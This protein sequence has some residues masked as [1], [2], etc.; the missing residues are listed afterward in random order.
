MP[1]YSGTVANAADLV[2]AIR[3]ACVAEG[4]TLTNDI[5]SK[6]GAFARLWSPA[7]GYVSVVS[8]RGQ[9]GGG[10]STLTGQ[11]NGGLRGI[12]GTLGGN[13]FAFPMNYYIHIFN[14]PDEVYVFVNY[15]GV[16]F[17]WL[18]FGKANTPG[19]VGTGNYYFASRQSSAGPKA[20]MDLRILDNAGSTDF[21]PF[22][23][24]EYPNGGYVGGWTGFDHSMDSDP[25]WVGCQSTGKVYELLTYCKNSWNDQTCLVPAQV[26]CGRPGGLISLVGEF[27]NMR[28]TRIDNYDPQEIISFGAE[29]WKLYPTFKK[30]T[31]AN[32]NLNGTDSSVYCMAIRYDGI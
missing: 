3:N 27:K 11:S 28:Y 29:Q 24:G 32:W 30:G 12:G 26:F 23:Y 1:Y 17:Q 31:V 8:G 15:S 20:S 10:G 5:L 18:G 19:L 14:N 16:C 6:S 13:A 22:P 9:T 2:T 25:S 21:C 7:A 4:W